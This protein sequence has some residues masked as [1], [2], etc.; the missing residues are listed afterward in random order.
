MTII[1]LLIFIQFVIL[2]FGIWKLSESFVYFYVFFIILSV[3]VEIYIISRKDN[4]SYKLAWTIL[5]L[6]L[7]VFGGLFYLLFG[8]NKTNKGFR[9][10]MIKSLNNIEPLLV[11][12]EKIINEIE[13]NSKTAANQANYINGYSSFPIYKNT[14]TE[15]L[16]P[17]EIFFEKLKEELKKAKHY[18]FM[19]YFII[20]EGEM[21]N[22]ILEILEKKVKEGVDVR[23]MYDDMGCIKTLPHKYNESLQNKGIKCSI[24][25]PF[26]PSLSMIMNNRDHRKITVIDGHTAFTGGINLADEYINSIVRFGH[27]KDASIMLKGD[28]VWNL[29]LMFL[30]L[31]N[32]GTNESEAYDKYRPNRYYKESFQSDGYVQPYGDSPLDGEIVGENVYLNIIN[33]ARNYVYI[34]TPYFIVDNELITALTLAAKSGIDV[35]IIT[36]HIEDKWYAHIV[37]T[38]YYAQLI[39]CGVKVYEYTPGFIHSKTF[40]ADDE[41]GTVG[42]IN[43]DYRSLYLHFECGV[44]LYKTKSVMQIKEDF[45][46]TLKVCEV[47][48]LEDCR[49]IKWSNVFVRSIL[50][51]F[52]PLM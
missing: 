10:R 26:V 7:P 29:T 24:F 30:H 37:T 16:S 39:E 5:V 27:W 19:E 45:L 38:A 9:K 51:V 23:V 22:S 35:R 34:T 43:M 17:G 40:V 4:P 44:W 48:T 21:W 15:Y 18:I 8:G 12:D 49:K 32:F 20:Q 6:A 33:K 41:I 52:A 25:N 13:K 1:G 14:Q 3:I 42:T 2:I 11:Q 50:R 31:W 46:N 28:A 47:V 36:P